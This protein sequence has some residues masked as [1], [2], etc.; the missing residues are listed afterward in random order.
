MGKTKGFNMN[1]KAI[2]FD[3][4]GTLLNTID[5]IA[6]SMN[7]VLAAFGFCQ[8]EVGKY[9]YFVGDGMDLLTRRSLPDSCKDEA[10]ISRCIS[11]MK[12]EYSLHCEDKT[13]A[14]DGIPELLD[15]LCAMG[16]KLAIL[17]NKPHE[18]TLVVVS[19]ML[20][21]W[22]FEPVLGARDGISKKPDPFAALEIANNLKIAP[23]DI[24]YLGDTQTDMKTALA[25]GMFPAGALW[26]FRKADELLEAGAK[27]L[28]LH[29]LDLL[30]FI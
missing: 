21:K 26:G 17:S 7:R 20:G 2:I 25:A 4:D 13:H 6:D 28:F 30:K 9:K 5:D 12:K 16:K 15:A 1:Y 19:G 10:L 23:D 24:L 11:A 22:K 29:P 18:Q 8:H 27:I 14:Y 3:L